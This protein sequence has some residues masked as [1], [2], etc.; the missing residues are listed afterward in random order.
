[1]RRI[2]LSFALL[3]LAAA[4]LHAQSV[5]TTV[6]AGINAYSVGVNPVTNKIYAANYGSN[7][8]TVIDGATNASCTPFT[9]EVL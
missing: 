8:V 9:E 5:T 3:L 1:M 6:T 4:G 7:D 2:S